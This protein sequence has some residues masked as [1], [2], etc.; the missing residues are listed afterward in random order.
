MIWIAWL[1]EERVSFRGHVDSSFWISVI[2][3]QVPFFSRIIQCFFKAREKGDRAVS[4]PE[5]N[6]KKDARYDDM[7]IQWIFEIFEIQKAQEVS[8]QR[9]QY[10]FEEPKVMPLIS[11]NLFVVCFENWRIQKKMYLCKPRDFTTPQK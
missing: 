8:E 9:V 4:S 2:D 5:E 7:A 11:F 10:I 6:T 3:G 1:C